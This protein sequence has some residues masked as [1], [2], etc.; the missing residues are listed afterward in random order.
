MSVVEHSSQP[1]SPGAAGRGSR[2]QF[3]ADPT[4]GVSGL[5]LQN[6]ECDPGVGGPSHTHEFE[7]VL[8]VIEGTVE[9]WLD[10]QRQ[11]VG[12]GTSVFIPTGVVHGFV[13]VG[14]GTLKLQFVIASNQMRASFVP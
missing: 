12:P 14:T 8:T 13:N 10:A 11:V 7:E 5:A 3:L 4:G 2:I 6:Q 9:V 1:W